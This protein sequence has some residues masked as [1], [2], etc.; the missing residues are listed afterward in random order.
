LNEEKVMQIVNSLNKFKPIIIYGWTTGIYKFSQIAI[1][2]DITLDVPSIKLI[3]PTAEKL[4]DYQR[5]TIEKFFNVEVR[6]EYG[7]SES[8]IIAFECPAGMKHIQVENNYVEVINI[9]N[10]QNGVGELIITSLNNRK[11]PLIRYKIGD[12][13]TLSNEC[14]SCGR[15]SPVLSNLSGRILDYLLDSSGEVILGEVFCYICFD[16]IDKYKAIKD[17][18]VRQEQDGSIFLYYTRSSGFTDDF[19]KIFEEEMRKHLGGKLKISFV[20]VEDFRNIDSGKTRYVIP[21]I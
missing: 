15:T 8:G 17:F 18:R 7:C 11:M 1:D 21:K 5:N 16:L 19:L 9:N 6:D 13:G 4:H 14:C 2:M 3:I 12:L 10:Y 20:W